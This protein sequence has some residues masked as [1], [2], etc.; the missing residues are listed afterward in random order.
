MP[1]RGARRRSRDG[2]IWLV[3]A[4]PSLQIL[5]SAGSHKNVSTPRV[6]SAVWAARDKVRAAFCTLLRGR[7]WRSG[8]ALAQGGRRAVGARTTGLEQ[9]RLRSLDSANFMAH[10]SFRL[11]TMREAEGGLSIV[12]TGR[13]Y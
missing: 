8:L 2:L 7:F 13:H 4:V 9:I 10:A 3:W 12:F 6:S 5:A 1:R 11:S